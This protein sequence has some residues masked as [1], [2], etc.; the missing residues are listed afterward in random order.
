MV[1]AKMSSQNITIQG[2]EIKETIT[3]KT[4][5]LL[6]EKLD[7]AVRECKEKTVKNRICV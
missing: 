4:R 2:K 6:D 5:A 7:N 1:E 3:S